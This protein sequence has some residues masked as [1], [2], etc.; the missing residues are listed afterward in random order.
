MKVKYA[1]PKQ[2]AVVPYSSA[3]CHGATPGVNRSRFW[4]VAQIVQSE[5]L[6]LILKQ[7][8]LQKRNVQ[9]TFKRR[10][11]AGSSRDL[12]VCA[13]TLVCARSNLFKGTS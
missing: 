12:P 9:I 5:H 7:Q 3:H 6:L 8:H 2:H 13:G 11:L 10:V 1:N 4:L